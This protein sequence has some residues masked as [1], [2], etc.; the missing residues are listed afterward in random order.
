MEL[1]NARPCSCH[2]SGMLH[3]PPGPGRVVEEATVVPRHANFSIIVVAS[4]RSLLTAPTVAV[5]SG[6]VKTG[7]YKG[8]EKGSPCYVLEQLETTRTFPSLLDGISSGEVLVLS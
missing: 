6:V 7:R 1:L 5:A 8:Q 4:S 2:T 3:K